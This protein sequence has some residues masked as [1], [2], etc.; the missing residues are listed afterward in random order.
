MEIDTQRSCVRCP[1]PSGHLVAEPGLSSSLLPSS[2]TQEGI[3]CSISPLTWVCLG[4][5]LCLQI[6]T[7]SVPHAWT[8][9]LGGGWGGLEYSW[10]VL[11]DVGGVANFKSRKLNK[12]PWFTISFLVISYQ[13]FHQLSLLKG[14][15][16][17]HILSLCQL[18]PLSAC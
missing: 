15:W 10:W 4:P 11:V 13:E 7:N 9:S 14:Y 17:S 8:L 1:E 12:G 6:A 2:P 18:L 3:V 16:V 5:F